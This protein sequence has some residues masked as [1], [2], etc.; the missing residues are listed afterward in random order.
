MEVLS[1]IQH[2][3]F[4]SDVCKALFNLDFV[5]YGKFL[6][7]IMNNDFIEGVTPSINLYGKLTF[8]VLLEKMLQENI[9]KTIV[10]TPITSLYN[11]NIIANYY[12]EFILMISILIISHTLKKNYIIQLILIVFI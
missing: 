2:E 1:F 7:Q 11:K 10:I 12:I 3:F 9:Y 8:R 5:I 4:K 6:R